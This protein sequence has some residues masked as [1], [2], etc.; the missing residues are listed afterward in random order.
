MY[1]TTNENLKRKLLERKI[2]ELKLDEV[3]K[4]GK[5]E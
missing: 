5:K 4:M 1:R 3:I 2:E